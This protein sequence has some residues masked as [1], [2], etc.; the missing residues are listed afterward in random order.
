[1]RSPEVAKKDIIVVG[2]SAGGVQALQTL[3]AGLPQNLD[4]SIFVVLHIAPSD[5]SLLAGILQRCTALPVIA[6]EDGMPIEKGRIYVGQPDH[7]LLIEEGRIRITRGPK[8]NR[9]RPSVDALFRSAAYCCG[10]RVIGVVLTGNLDDGTA[11]L[12]AVKERGGT[13]VVQDPQDAP[14]PSMPESALRY[15]SAD[16]VVPLAEIAPL[17]A[18]LSRESVVAT[19]EL[20]PKELEIETA[21]AKGS[22]GMDRE[23]LTL[24]PVSPYTC[25]ECQGVLVMLKDGGVPR[26][27][28]HT[29]HCYSVATLLAEMTESIEDSFWSAIRAVEESVLLLGHM[30]EHARARNDASGAQLFENQAA[31]AQQRADQVRAVVINHEV[32]GSR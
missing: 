28:C 15:V 18:R 9:H 5:R 21:I 16:H 8:E 26:F 27:R 29:G 25:P 30:A 13:A 24:G 11:G 2:A 17:L 14:H 1:M 22:Q 7:H 3:V 6:P 10:A 23:I 12:W 32:L 31:A 20:M 4:A 19:G